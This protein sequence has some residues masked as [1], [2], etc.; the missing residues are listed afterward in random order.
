MT[1]SYMIAQYSGEEPC[2]KTEDNIFYWKHTLYCP[3]GGTYITPSKAQETLSKKAQ[4]DCK[5]QRMGAVPWNT[6]LD[7]TWKQQSWTHTAAMDMFNTPSCVSE[8]LMRPRLFLR[9]CWELMATVVTFCSRISST[10]FAR[11]D[12]VNT[13]RAWDYKDNQ[14]N[15]N[16]V[17]K[18]IRNMHGT[19]RCG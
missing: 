14:L 9:N 3:K 6:P 16:A 7:R 15:W 18:N 2:D 13:Q 19:A 11:N 10:I 5:W 8:V 1:Y 4:A 17:I 12:T